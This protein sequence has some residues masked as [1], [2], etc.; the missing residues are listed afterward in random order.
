[1]IKICIDLHVKYPL[2]L[3]DF[4]ETRI[5]SKDCR[6]YSNIMIIRPVG[7]ALFRAQTYMKQL[8]DA[9]RNLRMRLKTMVSRMPRT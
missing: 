6:K 2:F 1:M 8:M 3:S 5:F 7:A 9:F 4:N